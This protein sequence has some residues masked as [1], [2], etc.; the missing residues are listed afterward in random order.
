MQ[1]RHSPLHSGSERKGLMDLV[2]SARSSLS[3]YH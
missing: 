2:I 1:L 3:L